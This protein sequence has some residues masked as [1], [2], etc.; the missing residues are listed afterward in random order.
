M[1]PPLRS[2]PVLVLGLL[3]ALYG[4]AEE[5]SATLQTPAAQ[6][7]KAA[8]VK[9]FDVNDC[10]TCH[11][12]A[13]SS[14]FLHSKHAGVEQS[15]Q[16][17]HAGAADHARVRMEGNEDK[18][19]S[20][21]GLKPAEINKTC[22][23]CHDSGHQANWT[24][25]MHER[26]NVA[27]TSCHSVHDFKSL[28]ANLKTSLEADTC[29]TCHQAIRAKG[30]RTSH[31]PVREGKIG[32][33]SC[34]DP[35]DS[36]TPKMLGVNWVNEKCLQCHTEK[37]GPFLWEHAPVRENCLNCHDPHGSNHDKLLVAK[38]PFLC[39]RCHLNTRHPG[40]LYDGINAL[41]G[42]NVSNR[43]IEHACKNCHQNVHGSNA[44]SGPYLG[45]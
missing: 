7:A 9:T 44:P 41:T 37:R 20:L 45:R 34:H 4:G 14:S 6:A 3:P 32:C 28:R 43:A 25:S 22:L 40:T 16:S 5:T 10:K 19:P 30:L 17:C 35:H 36:T 39:Q 8:D 27:C 38:Q 21:K 26:R 2:L 11:E 23:A 24:G 18:P 42:T 12:P 1:R 29:F 31:H 15:C 13:F 33:A